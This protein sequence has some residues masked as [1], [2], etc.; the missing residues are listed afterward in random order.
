MKDYLSNLLECK[1]LNTIAE[2][3]AAYQEGLPGK[4]DGMLVFEKDVFGWNPDHLKK[5][6][7]DVGIYTHTDGFAG[8]AQQLSIA[9]LVDNIAKSNDDPL[10]TTASA[11]HPLYGVIN[12]RRMTDTHLATWEFRKQ[13]RHVMYFLWMGLSSGRPHYD[14]FDNILLQLSGRK[15]VIVFPARV[16]D[17][18]SHKMRLDIV[19]SNYLFSKQNL[20]TYTWI[21]E[22]PYYEVILNPGEAITIPTAAYHSVTALSTDSV[23]ANVF[24]TP[25]SNNVFCNQFALNRRKHPWWMTNTKLSLSK[26]SYQLANKALWRSGPYEFF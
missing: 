26:L 6:Y 9:S 21:S 16:C 7:G 3:T 10:A 15:L 20:E 22:L 12:T 5:M 14:W 24:V 8:N 1:K 23:S 19:D 25:K 4:I 2:I 17:K 11:K 13:F 18:I